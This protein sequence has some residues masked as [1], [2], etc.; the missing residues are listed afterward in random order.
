MLYQVLIC[1]SYALAMWNT[2]VNNIPPP[3]THVAGRILYKCHKQ[4]IAYS[5]NICGTTPVT[6]HTSVRR[7]IVQEHQSIACYSKLFGCHIWNIYLQP[8][9]LV[10]NGT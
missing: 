5:V 10:I 9:V 8:I 1:S 2:A 6:Y 4:Y 3:G 7:C